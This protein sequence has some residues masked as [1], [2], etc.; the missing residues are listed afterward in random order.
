MSFLDIRSLV[1]L[2]DT[3]FYLERL[4]EL[5]RLFSGT[6]ISK[7]RGDPFWMMSGETTAMNISELTTLQAKFTNLRGNQIP[8][9]MHDVRRP[10]PANADSS[11]SN[12]G[13]F[14]NSTSFGDSRLSLK[15][16]PA[17]FSL[18]IGDYISV[19]FSTN[20]VQLYQ[21]Q[22]A[23]VANGFGV[24]PLFDVYPFLNQ[25]TILNNVVEMRNAGA[26]FVLT[27][28]IKTTMVGPMA[29]K[30]SFSGQQVMTHA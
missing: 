20:Y 17:G 14:V 10:R 15:G 9:L 13:L 1:D 28:P 2:E 7:E 21:C 16:L 19:T 12:T 4:D 27:E 25:S 11:F 5:G 30:I 6:T 24:T 8:F 26:L 22:E 18:T 3:S 29:G 23:V